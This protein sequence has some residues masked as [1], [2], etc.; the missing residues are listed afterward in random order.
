MMRGP[1]AGNP[2]PAEYYP[3][4]QNAR[5]TSAFP[6]HFAPPQPVAPLDTV[7][8]QR[9]PNEYYPHLHA[10]LQGHPSTQPLPQIPQQ[11]QQ[12][13]PATMN[14]MHPMHLH[15]S[16]AQQMQGRTMPPSA[17]IGVRIPTPIPGT[18]MY[19]AQAPMPIEAPSF[20]GLVLFA[21]PLAIGTLAV[22]ALALL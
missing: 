22:A 4:P 21:A 3:P 8:D 6:Q 2:V 17:P 11:H 18:A 10:Q 13:Y 12:A 16:T 7:R 15:A 14:P 19:P 20:F 9:D 5:T 1:Y